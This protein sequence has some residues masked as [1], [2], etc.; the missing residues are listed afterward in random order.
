MQIAG[1]LDAI[2]KAIAIDRYL[3]KQLVLGEKI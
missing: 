3:V 1:W 2:V